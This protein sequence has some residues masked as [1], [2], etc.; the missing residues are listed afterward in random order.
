[1]F[2]TKMPAICLILL[3][4]LPL[5]VTAMPRTREFIVNKRYLNIPVSQQQ[6]HQSVEFRAGDSS[7]K[8]VIRL[9]DGEPDYWVFKDL[10]AWMGRRLTMT[11]AKPAAGIELIYQ[12][13][14]FAGQDSLYHEIRRPQFH[15]SSRRGWNNDPNGLVWFDGEYHL[16][17][18]HNPFEIWWENMHWGHAVSGDLVHWRELD[19]ALYPDQMGTMFSGSAVIDKKNTSGWG[20]NALVAFYT[21]AGTE[22]VQCAAWSLDKGR[23]FTRYEGNPV[24]GPDR[25]PRVFWHDPSQSWVMALFDDAGIRILTS[26][27]LRQWVPQSYVAGFYECPELFELAVDG[28][29]DKK[30]WVMYGGSGTYMLGDFDGNSFTPV[31][32]K[33]RNTY[34]AHYAAQTFNDEPN[35]RRIQIGWGRIEHRG[36]PF[37]QMMCFPTELSLRT[38]NEGIRL[39]SEPLAE[40]SK[41]HRQA[42][43]LSGLDVA[44]A[45]GRL[46]A[47]SYDLLHVRARLESINGSQIVLQF[48]GQEVGRMDGD[49]LNGIQTPM[50]RPGTLIFEVE[51]LIDRTSIE[52]YYQK[53]QIVF[54]D[55]LR[56]DLA[57]TGLQIK[58]DEK[59]IRI[60]SLQVF[61]LAPI[62]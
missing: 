8:A 10:S 27:N 33:Y 39:F 60:H 52:S 31:R 42:H 59:N 46:A 51:L 25:D 22:R 35:G 1:M 5:L 20:T 18:Q 34:G 2:H 24:A 12:S 6:E 32:G 36:M 48:R 40:V 23:T 15:F 7:L 17:Y 11:F 3:L 41:L 13:D 49:E 50:D 55:P 43:D 47:I 53:G 28:R 58:G 21:A 38:T 61:E 29:T 9:A 62:W 37:N 4:L 26:A 16:F 54:V 57:A 56:E 19:D 44:T 14:S 45:N 30:Y